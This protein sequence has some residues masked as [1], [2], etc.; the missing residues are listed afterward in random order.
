[1]RKNKSR[2]LF[3]ATKAFFAVLFPPEKKEEV[4]K[5]MSLGRKTKVTV[6]TSDDSDGWQDIGFGSQTSFI[7]RNEIQEIPRTVI[8]KSK[9]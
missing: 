5:K 8:Q 3:K 6:F 1:M 9:K 4:K 7:P 2:S